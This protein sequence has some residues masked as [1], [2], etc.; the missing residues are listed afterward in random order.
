MFIISPSHVQY[1]SPPQCTLCSVA[2]C[3]GQLPQHPGAYCLGRD[4]FTLPPLMS[5][6]FIS[7]LSISLSILSVS[8]AQAGEGECG[9]LPGRGHGCSDLLCTAARTGADTEAP[10]N[11]GAARAERWVSGGA[12]TACQKTPPPFFTLCGTASG[13]PVTFGWPKG[14]DAWRIRD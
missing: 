13:T 11:G 5:C 8:L 9:A 14:P 12:A 2:L 3:S 6:L 7:L 10:A 1:I 4:T